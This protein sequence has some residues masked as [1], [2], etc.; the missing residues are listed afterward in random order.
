MPEVWELKDYTITEVETDDDMASSIAWF[1]RYNKNIVEASGTVK[2][3]KGNYWDGAANVVSVTNQK[4]VVYGDVSSYAAKVSFDITKFTP[5]QLAEGTSEETST[6]AGWDKESMWV[7]YVIPV[8]GIDFGSYELIFD[9][10]FDNMNSNILAYAMADYNGEQDA[11]YQTGAHATFKNSE[12]EDLGDGWYRYT[13]TLDCSNLSATDY[14][15]LSLDN[16]QAGYDKTKESTVY[17]DNMYL[18]EI[19]TY[20]VTVEGTTVSTTMT[21]NAKYAYDDVKPITAPADADSYEEADYDDLM[22]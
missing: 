22:G 8:G 21:M 16:R 4:D 18:N 15:V 19:I 6:W 9:A 5:E 7:G 10:K 14:V 2:V 20:T 12:A 3:N 17:I 1:D 13:L 11:A